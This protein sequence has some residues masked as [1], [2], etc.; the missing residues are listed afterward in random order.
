MLVKEEFIKLFEK[1]SSARKT[2]NKHNCRCHVLP[3]CVGRLMKPGLRP[4]PA[5]TEDNLCGNAAAWSWLHKYFALRQQGVQVKLG[6][7]RFS[8]LLQPCTVALHVP[9]RARY[10]TM[11]NH[12]WS[13]IAM[14]LACVQVDDKV[15]SKFQAAP[16]D[17]VHTFEP[18]DWMIQPYLETRLRGYK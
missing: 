18:N 8:K 10:A 3:Q 17:F 5:L 2:S 4:W 12:L 9:T 1:T 11:G 7:G 14:P 6:S 13:G 15:Y 16:L